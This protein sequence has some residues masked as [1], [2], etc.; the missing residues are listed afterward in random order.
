MKSLRLRFL[1]RDWQARALEKW[2]AHRRGI[3]E[4]VTGGGKTVF[5]QMC[6]QA[7]F[8]DIKS[9]QALI[10][11]PTVSLLDQWWVALQEES[12]VAADDIGLRSGRDRC[13]GD[14]PIVISVINSARS[15][16]K[17]FSDDRTLFLI[18]DECH[19][20]GSPANARALAG[21]FAATLGLSATPE[22]EYDDGF[23]DHIAP[24]LGPIIHRYTYVDASRDGVISPF[25][26]TNVEVDLLPDEE[27][28]Y[29]KYSRAI[30][31]ALRPG[32]HDEPDD[33]LKRLL[34]LRAAIAANATYR[35]PIAVKLVELHKGE[36]SVVFH[37]RIDAANHILSLLRTRGHRATI[38]HAAIGAAARR[39]NLRLFRRGLFDA[40]VCCRAL[41]EGIN[42]PEAAIA[43]VASS[44]ASNRQRIQRL[45]RILRT[46]PGKELAS[47]YTIF[48]TREERRRLEVEET[49][50]QG[51]ASVSWHHGRTRIDAQALSQG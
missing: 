49:N 8:D 40:L 42:V 7:F 9:G 28:A 25:T 45:G 51:V 43:V 39:D 4:V 11:V 33:K 19:R 36:R 27:E 6:L 23:Q 3:V 18:V 15:F 35:I 2:R 34:Q 44:T 1:P 26:L 37:E 32:S 24:Q 30:A 31:R 50:L 16:T 10:L 22:R 38:Y 17:N 46:A 21:T 48:A 12:G 5:A 41:D 14:E 29:R 13:V 47:V 20:A